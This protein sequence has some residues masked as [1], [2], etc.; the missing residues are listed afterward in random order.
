[1]PI[2]APKN[3]VRPSRYYGYYFCS[4]SGKGAAAPSGGG[5]GPKPSGYIL[6]LN[7]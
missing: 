6:S 3:L 4:A 5:K 7:I 2:M 1:M